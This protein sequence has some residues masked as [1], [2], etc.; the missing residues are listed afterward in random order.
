VIK[1]Q[2][3]TLDADAYRVRFQNSY[4]SVIDPTTSET[5]NYLQPSSVTQGLEFETTF[6]PVKGLSFYLNATA[7]NAY[8]EGKMNAGTVAAP[9]FQDAPS[10]LWVAQTPSDTEMQG[11][12]YSDKGLDLGF[13]NKRVGEQRVD[14]GQYHNQAIVGAFNTT[15]A[16]INYTVRN[17]SI[18]DQTKIQLSGD[19]LLNLHN[20]TALT[21]SNSATPQTITGTSYSDQFLGTTAI[22]GSDNP[23]FMSAR[24]LSISVTFGFAPRERK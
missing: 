20:M 13:F 18:F 1:L 19:N 5:V 2:R 10:G 22:S 23:T 8:Y 4:S 16:Y 11:V 6:V 7:A 14:S 3:F 9:Y 15:N 12:T 24:S 21:L 17:H